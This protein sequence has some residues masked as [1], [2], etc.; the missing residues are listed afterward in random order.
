MEDTYIDIPPAINEPISEY[1]PG[2]VER[3]NLKSKLAEMESDFYEIPIIIGGKEIHTGNQG[4]AGG[5]GALDIFLDFQ[6]EFL[7]LQ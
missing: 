2:S 5:Y 6:Y 1:A 7:F 3:A 4:Y